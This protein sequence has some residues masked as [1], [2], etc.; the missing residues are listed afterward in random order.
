MSEEEVSDLVIGLNI[1]EDSS[2]VKKWATKDGGGAQRNTRNNLDQL[3]PKA[4]RTQGANESLITA[5][6]LSYRPILL[7]IPEEK[8]KQGNMELKMDEEDDTR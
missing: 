8:H 2:L 1:T 3:G 4:L 7:S 6:I 5:K